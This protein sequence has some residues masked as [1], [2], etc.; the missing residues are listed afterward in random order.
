VLALRIKLGNFSPVSV[1]ANARGPT[2]SEIQLPDD[3]A[4]NHDF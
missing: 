2:L 3:A 4:V 1:T